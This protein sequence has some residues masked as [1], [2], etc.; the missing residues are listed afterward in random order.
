MTWTGVQGRVSVYRQRTGNLLVQ[1]ASANQADIDRV[2]IKYPGSAKFQ[3]RRASGCAA[4]TTGMA[5]CVPLTR[6]FVL[7]VAECGR[8]AMSGPDGV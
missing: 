6:L 2:R 1:R 8:R 4:D 7:I 3:A 5:W